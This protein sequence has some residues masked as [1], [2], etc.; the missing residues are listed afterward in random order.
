LGYHYVILDDC[1]S[2]G[3]NTSSNNSLIAG[4]EKFPDGIAAVADAI[5]ALGL[6]FGIYS[7]AGKYTCG[8][9]AGSLGYEDVDLQTWASTISNSW[10][11]AG[12]IDDMWD[13]PD[14][15]C[16]CDGQK[17]WDCWLPGFHCKYR[18]N[19]LELINYG[20]E[21]FFR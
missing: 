11:I 3:R 15:R 10:R 8:G 2:S 19:I 6:G 21:V 20:F 5:H 1:W 16:P 14:A 18:I 12:D 4:P 17:A 7:D 13:T 9:F